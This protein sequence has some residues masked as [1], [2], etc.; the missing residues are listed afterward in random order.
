MLS[1]LYDMFINEPIRFSSPSHVT[2]TARHRVLRRWPHATAGRVHT[3]G[4]FFA[5]DKSESGTQETVVSAVLSGV[6]H[7]R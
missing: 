5:T 1:Q 3:I 4:R 7:I 6:F 2:A